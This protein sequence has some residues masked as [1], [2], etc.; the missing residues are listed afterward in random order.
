MQGLAG[1]VS[2]WRL[3]VFLLG[4]YP[5]TGCQQALC[6]QSHPSLV[7]HYE[8]GLWKKMSWALV[9]YRTADRLS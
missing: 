8:L 7:G 1:V 2:S 6:C 9:C 4:D 3:A 5:F